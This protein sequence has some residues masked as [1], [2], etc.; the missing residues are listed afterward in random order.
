MWLQRTS[1][2]QLNTVVSSKE[3]AEVEATTTTKKR[4]L[5]AKRSHGPKVQKK[6]VLVSLLFD[7]SI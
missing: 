7:Y 4:E 1:H 5:E 3:S 6:R 2:L